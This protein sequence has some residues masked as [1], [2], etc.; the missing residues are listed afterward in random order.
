MNYNT[1]YNTR[2]EIRAAS[3][4]LSY[5][6]LPRQRLNTLLFVHSIASFIIG[7]IGYLNPGVAMLFFSMDTVRERGL[8]RILVRLFCSL[9]FAQGIMIYRARQIN[10][11]EVKRAFI[12]AYFV[13][14]LFSTL[15]LIMA[16]MS[17]EGIVEGKLFGVM[18]IMY[19]MGLTVGYGWFTFRQPPVV[20]S[21][22]GQHSYRQH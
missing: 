18:K 5:H 13:C 2:G 9:I 7:G 6:F 8:G 4:P 21:L 14:F 17:N 20:Y 22:S 3:P 16:H 12:L 10:D 15:A 19:M 1:G 11:G